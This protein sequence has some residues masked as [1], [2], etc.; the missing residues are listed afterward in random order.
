MILWKPQHP[1]IGK[2]IKTTGQLSKETEDKLIEAIKQF[3]KIR[4]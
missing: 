2:D 4:G 3:K 1:E